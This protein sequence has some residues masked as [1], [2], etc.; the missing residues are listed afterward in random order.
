MRRKTRQRRRNRRSHK[1]RKQRGGRVPIIKGRHL[2]M[3]E[4]DDRPTIV[5]RRVDPDDE[6]GASSYA[7][8]T[9]PEA[10]YAAEHVGPYA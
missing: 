9:I 2:G 6:D 1:T 8:F 7:T 4:A 5:F 3:P 10:E